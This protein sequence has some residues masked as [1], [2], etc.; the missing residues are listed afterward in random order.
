[1][2]KDDIRTRLGDDATDLLWMEC[3]GLGALLARSKGSRAEDLYYI[4]KWV[5]EGFNV[6]VGSKASGAIFASGMC[7]VCTRDLDDKSHCISCGW[8]R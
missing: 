8:P 3:R 2:N 4:W 7:P 5:E 1:M 6:D